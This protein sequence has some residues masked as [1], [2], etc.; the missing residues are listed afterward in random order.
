MTPPDGNEAMSELRQDRTTGAWAIIA[1]GRARR[2]QDRASAVRPAAPSAAWRADCPF[3]PGN[4]A[5]LLGIVAETRAPG[6]PGWR[7][8]AVPNKFP[9]L[10]LD[11]PPVD[12]GGHVARPGYGL[13]EV[14]IESPRHDAALAWMDEDARA[15][16]VDL[17]RARLRDLLQRPAI[18]SVVLFRNQ[19]PGGG[20]SLEHPHAQI[21]ALAMVPPYIQTMADWGRRHFAAHG[22]CATCR[23]L[24]VECEDGARLIE[25]T[26][27]FVALV[28]YAAQR[29]GEVWIV[30]KRHRASFAA[31][32]DAELADF[33]GLLGRTL[34][35]IR[36]ALGDPAYN[37]VFDN[38]PR[39]AGESPDFHWRL[40]I[41]PEV[42][43]WGG[44]ERGTGLPINP[45]IP[46]DDAAALRA[47]R[48][49]A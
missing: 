43:A 48:K 18:A 38:A 6:E 29:A 28:P 42:T 36:T 19:G 27:S 46:E 40:R 41:I 16:T 21:V 23:E 45:S 7:V 25:Q 37:F 39:E 24:A 22:Q 20:A 15:A 33:A 32:D 5:Q 12:A 11:A 26:A 30:P 34:V 8:R 1:P 4:E 2:P 35:R 9:A 49:D 14:L 3:C 13:H 31:T 47:R 44:F 10:A 17:Y